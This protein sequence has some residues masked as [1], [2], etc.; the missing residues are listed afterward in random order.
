MRFPVPTIA[1]AAPPSIAT[2]SPQVFGAD[3]PTID[4]LRVLVVDDQRDAREAVAAVLEQCGAS[5]VAA[6]DADEGLEALGSASVDVMISDIGMP[7]TDGYELIRQ[8]RSHTDERVARTP[9]L[10]LTA[11]GGLDDQ[12]RVF[13]AGF[14][15]YL[16]KPVDANQLLWAV[17]RLGAR[18]DS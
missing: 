1:M 16:P 5:V 4:G 14:D 8:V 7:V 2:L 12:R 18:R 15:A 11:Y 13:D 9:S 10:A 17:A 6:G 3:G